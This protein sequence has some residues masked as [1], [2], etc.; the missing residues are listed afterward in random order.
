MFTTTQPARYLA[1]VVT[2][3]TQSLTEVV[4]LSQ[5][6]ATLARNAAANAAA[7]AGK[8]A[9]QT[10]GQGQQTVSPTLPVPVEQPHTQTRGRVLRTRSI[11]R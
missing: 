1:V 9:E 2:R 4:R 10:A 11:S 7:A 6:T 8:T 3:L 5:A